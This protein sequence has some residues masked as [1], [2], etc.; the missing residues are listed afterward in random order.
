MNVS[1]RSQRTSVVLS[2]FVQR[3]R[4]VMS[5]VL[6]RLNTFVRVATQPAPTVAIHFWNPAVV[7]VAQQYD[8]ANP[9]MG[10]AREWT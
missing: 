7:L 2:G 10:K 5:H 6:V 9:S 8:L 4:A 3:V 1:T